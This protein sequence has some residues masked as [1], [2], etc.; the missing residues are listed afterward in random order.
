[1]HRDVNYGNAI[2]RVDDV[3]SNFVGSVG[4]CPPGGVPSFL[5]R[6]A[7]S[8]AALTRGV[9]EIMMP[10]PSRAP[11][12]A[13]CCLLVQDRTEDPELQF[14]ASARGTAATVG[15]SLETGG[16][17]TGRRTYIESRFFQQA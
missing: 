15:Y 2:H 17:S 13:S 10:A 11:P 7:G 5:R 12:P 14:C 16:E 3:G 8:A 4:A 6:P 9:L 1:M